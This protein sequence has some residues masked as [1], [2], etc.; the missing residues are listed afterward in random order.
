M[1]TNTTA[2]FFPCRISDMSTA[3]G[4]ALSAGPAVA[5]PATVSA[6]LAMSG[7]CGETAVGVGEVE[8]VES[9]CLLGEGGV[10][11]LVVE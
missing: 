1:A 4:P 3:A 10:V 7:W 8:R 6:S 9:E 5:G 2:S 11:I